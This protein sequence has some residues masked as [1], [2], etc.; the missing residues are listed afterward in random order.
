[1][2]RNLMLG[3]G[4]SRHGGNSLLE[5]LAKFIEHPWTDRL[6]MGLI[7]ANAIT[8]GLETSETVM[9]RFGPILTAFDRF[10]IA[11][12]VIEILARLI[13]QRLSFFKNGWNI[14]DVFVV[15]VALAPAT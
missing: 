9:A 13:V 11:V 15:G 5:R 3:A 7:V 14:F 12:F 2:A 4:V 8:L 10:V 1:I 6:I